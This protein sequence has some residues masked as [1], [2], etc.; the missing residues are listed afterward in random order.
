MDDKLRKVYYDPKHPGSF[1]GVD[2]LYQN[3]K[4][5]LNITK[6]QVQDWLSRQDTYTLHK[7]IQRRFKRNRVFVTAIDEQWELDLVDM[8]SLKKYNKQYKFLITCIDVLSKY[9]WV[10]PIKNKSADT[11]LNAIKKL[12]SGKRKPLK[13]HTDK[14]T[15]F[16]NKTYISLRQTMKQKPASSKDLIDL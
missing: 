1:G 2:R 12:L 15:E 5:E 14:G 10:I 6:R 7:P 9:A 8:T 16:T 11:M 4:N 13:I 3:V